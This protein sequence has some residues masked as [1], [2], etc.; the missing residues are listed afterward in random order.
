[1]DFRTTAAASGAVNSAV[2]SIRRNSLLANDY[3]F[4]AFC[5]LDLYRDLGTICE[6]K[7]FEEHGNLQ[8]EGDEAENAERAFEAHGKPAGKALAFPFTL[9]NPSNAEEAAKNF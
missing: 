1:V 3:A 2:L 8:L 5:F 9:S 7:R 4:T 6:L